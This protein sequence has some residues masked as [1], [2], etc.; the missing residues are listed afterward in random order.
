MEPY[1]LVA[2]LLVG[3]LTVSSLLARRG[4]AM[5]S[6]AMASEDLIVDVDPARW[7]PAE[8]IRIEPAAADRWSEMDPFAGE[9]PRPAEPVAVGVA[10]S[11]AVMVAMADA[12][13]QPT[14]GVGG[15]EPVSPLDDLWSALRATPP[16]ARGDALARIEHLPAHALVSVANAHARDEDAADRILAVI[17]ARLAGDAGVPALL[18]ALIDQAPRVRRAA[19]LGLSGASP[20][21]EV[22]RALS[23]V[24]REDL[25]DG[26]RA[27]AMDALQQL[28]GAD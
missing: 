24:A 4:R 11:P 14:P 21:I 23:A 16:S 15:S 10:A 3:G 6:H 12:S 7:E 5:L 26:V 27:E 1:L 9:A 8:A 18:N 20:T 13:S 17:F 22:I 28:T 19:A 25:D 2:A